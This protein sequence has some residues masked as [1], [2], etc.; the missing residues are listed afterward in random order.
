[1]RL[2]MLEA[3]KVGPRLG[4]AEKVDVLMR[5]GKTQARE[6]SKSR[7][8]GALDAVEQTHAVVRTLVH[9]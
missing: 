4:S 2:V 9:C 3:G 6:T 1:M 8:N 7:L 5:V